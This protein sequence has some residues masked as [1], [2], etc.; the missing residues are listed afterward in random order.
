MD[1]R[2]VSRPENWILESK[3]KRQPEILSKGFLARSNS[4]SASFGRLSSFVRCA[5]ESGCRVDHWE[6][7]ARERRQARVLRSQINEGK[8]G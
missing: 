1:G 7:S 4:S 2:C 5:E 8:F 6:T 3:K